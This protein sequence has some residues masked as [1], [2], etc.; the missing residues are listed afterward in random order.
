MEVQEYRILKQAVGSILANGLRYGALS[1][2]KQVY[3]EGTVPKLGLFEGERVPKT[4]LSSESLE[5]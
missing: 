2:M 4:G 1:A 3:S 5:Q